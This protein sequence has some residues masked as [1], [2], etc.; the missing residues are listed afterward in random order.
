[1][2]EKKITW[3]AAIC[4]AGIISGTILANSLKVIQPEALALFAVD[5]Y[6]AAGWLRQDWKA[7]FFY[8][9]KQRGIQFLILFAVGFWGNSTAIVLS[10]SF[11]AGMV[12]SLVISIETMRLGIHGML[13]VLVLF[14]PHGIFYVA[15]CGSFFRRK[16]RLEAE[17]G[18]YIEAVMK[19]ILFPLAFTMLGILMESMLTPMMIQWVMTG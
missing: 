5:Q 2:N 7:L 19:C 9:L 11:F 4:F 1:M 10:G 13:L 12:W 16:K 8:L 14:L 15:A 3:L 18:R 6:S 17:N